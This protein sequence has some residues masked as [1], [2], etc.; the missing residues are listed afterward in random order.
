MRRLVVLFVAAVA[1]SA[2]HA[3]VTLPLGRKITTRQALAPGDPAPALPPAA[4]GDATVAVGWSD[5]KATLVNFW[6]EWCVPCRDEMPALQA[7]HDR[8]RKDGLEIV[9][10]ELGRRDDARSRKFVSDL[11]VKYPIVAADRN[12]GNEWGIGIL[13]TTF[14][15]GRDGKIVRRYAGATPEQTRGLAV[16]VDAFLDGKPLPMQVMSEPPAEPKKP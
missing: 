16:D 14:L 4:S 8:R 2:A 3:Q 9:G 10:V 15:I 12:V 1:V 7:L 11:G 6:A 5:H 13:P